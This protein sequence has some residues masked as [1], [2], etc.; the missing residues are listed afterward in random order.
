MAIY[1]PPTAQQ[2]GVYTLKAAALDDFDPFFWVRSN[3]QLEVPRARSYCFG[4]RLSGPGLRALCFSCLKLS[5]Q[6][7]PESANRALHPEGMQTLPPMR[8]FTRHMSAFTL[9]PVIQTQMVLYA[10]LCPGHA[11]GDGERGRPGV[12]IREAAQVARGPARAAGGPQADAGQPDHAEVGLCSA[13]RWS[14]HGMKSLRAM[15]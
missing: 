11:E 2:P 15:P 6:P 7:A 8:M 10:A 5:G 12:A 4:R 1:K 14:S 9:G 13:F 3:K